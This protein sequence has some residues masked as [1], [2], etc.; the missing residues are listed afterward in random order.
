MGHSARG[1]ARRWFSGTLALQ[2]GG[3]ISQCT[4]SPLLAATI[5]TQF[6]HFVTPCRLAYF[7][8]HELVHDAS[9]RT[10][11]CCSFKQKGGASCSRATS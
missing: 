2:L 7:V 8:Y 6:F 5:L 3:L 1:K 10:L 11:P 9:D 4:M